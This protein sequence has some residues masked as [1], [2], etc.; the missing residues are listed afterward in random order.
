MKT[1]V[2][3]EFIISSFSSSIVIIIDDCLKCR[4]SVVS[5]SPTAAKSLYGAS[6][7]ANGFPSQVYPSSQQPMRAPFTSVSPTRASCL[8]GKVHEHIPTCKLSLPLRYSNWLEITD[9]ELSDTILDICDKQGIEAVFPGYGFLSENADFARRVHEAGMIFVG[10]DSE[11]I[12]K[13]GLKHV[14]RDLATAAGI[15]V[16]Q[17]SGLLRNAEESLR[18][19]QDV[20]FPVSIV[21][22]CSFA[23]NFIIFNSYSTLYS[24]RTARRDTILIENL[25]YAK[26]LGW[27]RWY[28]PTRV[29]DRR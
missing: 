2:K 20:G 19:A 14:A 15:P 18:L 17:G 22:L 21:Y 16:I 29:L 26:G 6:V 8:T 24:I 7:H 3:N 10:P 28:G 23:F 12:Y 1:V 13:M 9:N 25:G 5:S 11:A 4:P 27:R